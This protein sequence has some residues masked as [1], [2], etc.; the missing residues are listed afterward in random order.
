VADEDT[1]TGTDAGPGG[2]LDARVGQLETGQASISDKVDRILGIIGGGGNDSGGTSSEAD[3]GKPANVA[4]EI[5]RQIEARDARDAAA[6]DDQARTD[7]LGAL[8]TKL[9]ELAE[10]PPEPMPRRVEKLMGWR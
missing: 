2:D 10:K 3:Q 8:E 4:E 7:R 1:G 6:A 5:R 9:A